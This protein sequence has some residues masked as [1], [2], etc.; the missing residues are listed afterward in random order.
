[1]SRYLID[2]H[3]IT[4]FNR[5]KRELQTFLMFCVL[6]AGKNSAVQ[7]KKLNEFL[8][9]APNNMLP[10]TYLWNLY[11]TGRLMEKMMDHKLGQY[12]RLEQCFKEIMMYGEDLDN[13]NVM[14]L[15]AFSGIGPKTARFFLTH[16]R[17]NTSFAVLDTHV[18]RWMREELGVP[19]PKNTPS[20]KQYLRLEKEFLSAC[21]GLGKSPAALDLEIWS[22]YNRGV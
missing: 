19:T 22:R 1:M 8:S 18:L 4:N 21:A 7:A 17:P 10:F 13:I 11:Y 14:M 6:V 12:T 15:E 5:S 20:G 2:S 3:D 9:E 16:S